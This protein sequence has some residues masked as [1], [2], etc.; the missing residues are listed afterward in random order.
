MAITTTPEDTLPHLSPSAPPPSAG[1][2]PPTESLSVHSGSFNLFG[3]LSIQYTLDLDTLTIAASLHAFGVQVA[4]GD[5]SVLHPALELAGNYHF[6]KWDLK[7]SL[8]VPQK[9]LN[10]SGDACL[11][12]TGC[13]SFSITLLKW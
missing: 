12:A 9:Q 7:L 2:T 4:G 3:P 1:T 13:K 5:L 10:L 11:E 6:A 8:D